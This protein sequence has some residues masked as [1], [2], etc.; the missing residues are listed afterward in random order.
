MYENQDVYGN[1][2]LYVG[3]SK[4]MG[5]TSASTAFERQMER[6]FIY[7]TVERKQYNTIRAL[8][9]GL[10]PPASIERQKDIVLLGFRR[11]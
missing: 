11:F 5:W 9:A 6:L 3:L 10:S 2:V 1:E 7:Y 4:M 8:R